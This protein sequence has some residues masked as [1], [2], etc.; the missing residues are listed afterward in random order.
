MTAW[1][2]ARCL[3]IGQTWVGSHGKSRYIL[4]L[5]P[6]DGLVDPTVK[7]KDCQTG[8]NQLI[9]LASMRTWMSKHQARMEMKPCA[10]PWQPLAT[11]P[12]SG[13]VLLATYAPTNWTYWVS[14]I[15]LHEAD[16]PRLREMRLRY[17][18]GWMWAPPEPREIINE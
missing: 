11:L 8:E 1:C 16:H 9:T 7:Y 15:V 13:K 12:K 18:R 17:A 10:N 5:I 14:T 2:K 3:E 6:A 4:E